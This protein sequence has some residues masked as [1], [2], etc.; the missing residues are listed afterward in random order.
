MKG[1]VVEHLC[2]DKSFLVYDNLSGKFENMLVSVVEF[3]VY[4]LFIIQSLILL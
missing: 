4:E 2:H 3:A 1:K